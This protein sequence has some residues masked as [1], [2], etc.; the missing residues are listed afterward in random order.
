MGEL[1]SAALPRALPVGAFPNLRRAGASR[2]SVNRSNH[3]DHS[4]S[5]LS[6]QLP[7]QLRGYVDEHPLFAD[8]TRPAVAPSSNHKRNIALSKALRAQGAGR[9]QAAP[10]G[11]RRDG[12]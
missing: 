2:T 7:L 12:T 6:Q 1:L 5:N 10:L 9:G 3:V 4:G 11:A 8:T